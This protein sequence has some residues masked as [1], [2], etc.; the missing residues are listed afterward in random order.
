MN[1]P[2]IGGTSS[3]GRLKN[4]GQSGSSGFSVEDI[5]KLSEFI[6]AAQKVLQNSSQLSSN[7]GSSLKSKKQLSVKVKAQKAYIGI[8][9]KV[10]SFI[11]CLRKCA[12]DGQSMPADDPSLSG[13]KG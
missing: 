5:D 3:L 12:E 10:P 8:F 4:D 11:N 7:R 9:E 13:G 6:D 2:G 1:L